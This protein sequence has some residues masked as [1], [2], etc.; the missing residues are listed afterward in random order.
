MNAEDK[1]IVALDVEDLKTAQD[2]VNRLYPTVK[3]FKIGSPLFTK[4]GPQAV[5]LIQ[6]KGAKVFLDLK[7]Y[8]IPNT[9]GLSSRFATGLGVFMFNVH[10]QGGISMMKEA[11]A[12][13][14]DEA[15]KL[16]ITKPII[17]G[18]TILTSMDEKELLDIGIRK[19]IKE[20]VLYLAR[21]AKQAGLDGVVCAP[22]EA[23]S[24]RWACGEDFVIVTPGIRP[25]WAQ[26]ADQKRTQTPKEAVACGANYIVVGRPII[27][28]S[29]PL[30]AIR[31]VIQEVSS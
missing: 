31:K 13:S 2:L 28:A 7:F 29:D 3:I 4:E 15:N 27:E 9:V 18:V 26:P 5:S 22:K 25:A 11:K 12:A 14:T 8:D 19:G 23:Q 20:Q 21:L 16:K 1:L 6:K 10:I 17:L 30:E 24:I